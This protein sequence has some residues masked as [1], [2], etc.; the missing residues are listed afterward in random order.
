MYNVISLVFVTGFETV[1]ERGTFV[2]L[3][4]ERDSLQD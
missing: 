3:Y 2:I 4:A 1:K